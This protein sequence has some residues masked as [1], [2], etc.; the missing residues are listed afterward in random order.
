MA[1]AENDI[2]D[3]KQEDVQQQCGTTSSTA[4]GDSSNKSG[5]ILTVAM[6]N[7]SLQFE[8]QQI[9]HDYNLTNA[10]RHRS[11][12]MRALVVSASFQILFYLGD[13]VDS[14][15]TPNPRLVPSVTAPVRLMISVMQLSFLAMLWL[16]LIPASQPFILAGS[17]AYAVPTL[18]MFSLQK[19]QMTQWD[20]S[21]VIIVNLL[22]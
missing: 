2:V 15:E 11:M 17:L 4:V 20:V 19:E 8:D 7:F 10:K 1:E 12:W 18:L 9:E 6:N 13:V 21:I 3:E 14:L 5:R 22:D 16:N